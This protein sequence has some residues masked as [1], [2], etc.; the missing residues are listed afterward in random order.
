MNTQTLSR[1][2][3]EDLNGSLQT[4]YRKLTIK[5]ES[6]PEKDENKTIN[7][8]SPSSESE[9]SDQNHSDV[10]PAIGIGI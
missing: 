7:S 2:S 10:S 6:L 3:R 5:P 9:Q 8:V 4:L 1:K